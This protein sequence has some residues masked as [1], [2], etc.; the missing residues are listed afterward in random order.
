MARNLQWPG[1]VKWEGGAAPTISVADDAID[2]IELVWD[3]AAYLGSFKQ[4]IA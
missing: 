1:T 3:G 4:A 2:L